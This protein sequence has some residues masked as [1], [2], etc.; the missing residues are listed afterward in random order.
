MENDQ[1]KNQYVEKILQKMRDQVENIGKN[2]K[3]ME[4]ENKTV[5]LKNKPIGSF[6][7]KQ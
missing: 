2:R 4:S 5:F 6:D 1:S 3:Q 7:K